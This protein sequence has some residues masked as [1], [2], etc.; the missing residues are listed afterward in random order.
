MQYV[1]MQIPASPLSWDSGQPSVF[2]KVAHIDHQRIALPVAYGIT[3]VRRIHVGAMR[4]TVG[5]Y[6][7]VT[8]RLISISGVYLI[9]NHG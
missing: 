4:P 9:E 8:S 6:K 3:E 5:R 2:I 1:G 7:A